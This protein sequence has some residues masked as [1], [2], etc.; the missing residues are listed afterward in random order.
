V[1]SIVLTF[2]IM[3][4]KVEDWRLFCQELSDTHQ[5][6]YEASRVAL[7]I[8][9]ERLAL[10]ETPYGATAI[11]SIEASDI[12]RTLSKMLTSNLEFDVWYRKKVQELYDIDLAGYIQFEQREPLSVNPDV[13]FEW[14][15]PAKVGQ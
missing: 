4:G 8:T 13:L 2:P 3:E 11:N 9:H 12:D 10:V 1:S 7:G 6:L 5:T 14:V 15:L